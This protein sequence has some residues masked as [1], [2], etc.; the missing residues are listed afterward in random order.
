VQKTVKS[1]LTD[2]EYE[3]Q[4]TAQFM[5]DV[6]ITEYDVGVGAALSVE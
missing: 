5:R 3:A 1:A 2:A 6:G 4:R